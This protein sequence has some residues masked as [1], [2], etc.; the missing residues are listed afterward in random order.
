MIVE[1]ASVSSLIHISHT[2]NVACL[3]K[4]GQRLCTF[5]IPNLQQINGVLPVTRHRSAI[6][7]LEVFVY[8]ER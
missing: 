5:R 7:N 6:S 4:I 8:G 3:A 2:Y 1:D